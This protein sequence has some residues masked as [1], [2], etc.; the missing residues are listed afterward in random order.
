MRI[1]SIALAMALALSGCDSAPMPTPAPS[2]AVQ[3]PS[4]QETEASIRK[5][6]EDWAAVAVTGD[7]APLQGILADDYLGVASTGEVRTKAQQ[8]ARSNPKPLFKASRVDYINFRHFGDTVIAQ[9]AETLEWRDGK[10]DLRLIWTDIWMF[11][12]GK[13]QVAASQDSV[14]PPEAKPAPT[15]SGG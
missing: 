2:T 10:P 11:R 12:D 13:W 3:M 15:A 5:G 6:A 1:C 9:G 14:R 8:L 4:R 7:T